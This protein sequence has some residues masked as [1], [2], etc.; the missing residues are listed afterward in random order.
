MNH[1]HIYL[2]SL[3]FSLFGLFAVPQ[4]VSAQNL[5]FDQRCFTKEQCMERRDIL[6]A[7]AS[8][9][10]PNEGFHQHQ[11]SINA[12]SGFK[13]LNPGAEVGFCSA[14]KDIVT[15][16]GFGGR[17]GFS[18][19]ADFIAYIFR[20]S[21]GVATAIAV[22]MVIVGGIQWMTSAGNSNAVAEAKKRITGATLGIVLLATSY[23]ILSTINQSLVQFQPLNIYLINS[24]KVAPT[25]CD[26]FPTPPTLFLARSNGSSSR[27]PLADAVL[28]SPVDV[29]NAKCGDEFYMAQAGETTC[30]GR[31]CS[32]QS[33]PDLQCVPKIVNGQ[34][35]NEYEC[36][37]KFVAKIFM[38][39]YRDLSAAGMGPAGLAFANVVL[40]DD[41][42]KGNA[43]MYTVCEGRFNGAT[44]TFVEPEDGDEDGDV[45]DPVTV[46]EHTL[47]K[48]PNHPLINT[49]EYYILE[50]DTFGSIIEDTPRCEYPNYTAVGVVIR[51]E[52][53]LEYTNEAL[54]FPSLRDPKYIYIGQN[55]YISPKLSD[56]VALG[57]HFRKGTQY[58]GMFDYDLS[59]NVLEN[60]RDYTCEV[61]V[62]DGSIIFSC[63]SDIIQN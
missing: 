20:Y 50:V 13:Q 54:G 35:N 48:G 21:F 24:I 58:S 29:T 6:G 9:Q 57:Q 3:C 32:H 22:V 18:G 25:Y 59:R 31:S 42:I 51:L 10:R 37:N 43:E 55:G 4:S 56:V 41:W 38:S 16:S 40:S 62:D 49:P 36:A 19:I 63:P 5:Q 47:T 2:L 11:L 17:T 28:Q 8:T 44:L 30:M 34:L 45:E 7:T 1:L 60:V 15:K 33:D 39:N 26:D 12:C 14:G 23:L 53:D 52:L 61:E 46:P 27:A